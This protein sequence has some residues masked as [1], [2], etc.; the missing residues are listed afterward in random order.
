[1]HHSQCRVSYAWE[2][3][4]PTLVSLGKTFPFRPSGLQLGILLPQLPRASMTGMFP[5]MW[6]FPSLLFSAD[7]T[8][9]H[10]PTSHSGWEQREWTLAGGHWLINLTFYTHIKRL[11]SMQKCSWNLASRG[12]SQG[13]AGD[14]SQ[15]QYCILLYKILSWGLYGF[16]DT[17]FLFDFQMSL[18]VL[19]KGI[20]QL[21]I[22]VSSAE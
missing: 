20:V 4:L 17:E 13:S 15:S 19:K 18:R 3:L 12:L 7:V 5:H 22:T 8:N 14:V 10:H 2:K 16:G 21:S 11:E 9:E 1:M 6:P